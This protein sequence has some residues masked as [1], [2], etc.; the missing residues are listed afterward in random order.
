M[1]ELALLLVVIR[2]LLHV[3][4]LTKFNDNNHD[5]LFP[6][7]QWCGGAVVSLYRISTVWQASA[8]V[9]SLAKELLPKRHSPGLDI[10]SPFMRAIARFSSV[11]L[12]HKFSA[13]HQMIHGLQSRDETHHARLRCYHS[14]S[15]VHTS[16]IMMLSNAQTVR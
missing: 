7:S 10:R 16:P 11:T 13:K 15:R 8:A 9:V 1:K 4:A 3:T 12:F 6:S 14:L 5:S 2:S